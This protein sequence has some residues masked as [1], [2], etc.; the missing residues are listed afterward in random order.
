[1]MRRITICVVIFLP[2]I[3]SAQWRL[4]VGT[5][6]GTYKMADMKYIQDEL[7]AL[8]GYIP[9]EKVS[10]FPPSLQCELMID[11]KFKN[12]K[13]LGHYVNYALT[14]GRAH[15]ADYSGDATL[16][17]DLVRFGT[18]FK[19]LA[20]MGS[21][22][23]YFYAKSGI[24]FTSFSMSVTTKLTGGNAK[25]SSQSFDAVGY[26]F[27]PGL[28][29]QKE[30]KRFVFYVSSGY[31]L[32]LNGKTNSNSYEGYITNRTGGKAR[33]DWSG[34]RIGLGAAMRIRRD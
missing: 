16:G 21:R 34:A 14:R 3:V 13:I 7:K 23:F 4:H 19:Y 31:E 22:G 32:C 28:S 29:W 2:T 20:P 8:F 12:K 33:I 30:Y 15:Y 10:S 27:E 25:K 17:Q 9:F 24:I 11:R 5:I 18:G 6:A 26:T 1:M